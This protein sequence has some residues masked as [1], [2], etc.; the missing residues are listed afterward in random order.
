MCETWKG[1]DPTKYW[2]LIFWG[3]VMSWFGK[4]N[5]I[6]TER[7]SVQF[8]KAFKAYPRIF[9]TTEVVSS[10]VAFKALRTDGK[11]YIWINLKYLHFC[12][13][14]VFCQTNLPQILVSKDTGGICGTLA[15]F[16]LCPTKE[17]IS[18]PIP[19]FLHTRMN[20]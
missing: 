8:T 6:F 9:W 15:S 11:L 2:Y 12:T 16:R 19:I 10:T 13:S 20:K 14:F 18:I 1:R 5:L 17:I 7:I 4:R 3:H